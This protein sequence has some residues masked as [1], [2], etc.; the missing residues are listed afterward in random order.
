[1]K[2]INNLEELELLYDPPVERSIKKVTPV[3]T[4]L[5]RQ[6]IESS[7]FLVMATVGE[8]GCDA[9]PRGDI[10]S[11]VKIPDM[12]TIWL[13]DWRGN[14]RLDSLRNIVRDGRISLMFMVNGCNNVVRINGNAVLAADEQTRY[15]F[16]RN[17]KAPKTVIVV[18][19]VEVYFQCAK[20][21]MR[22]DLWNAEHSSV[23]LPSAGDFSKEQDNSFDSKSYDDGY[24][25]YAKK[26]LW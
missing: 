21:L 20:A 12:N 7:R 19:V 18:T 15:T 10:D 2:I 8:E 26:I 9:S 17:D 23:S 25:E 6:W 4:P 3:I 11:L 16:L 1:M 22:S 5:Y 24:D 14:N 13:P